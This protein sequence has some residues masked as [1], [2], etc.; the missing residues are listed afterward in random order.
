MTEKD[1][2]DLFQNI[3]EFQKDSPREEI[4]LNLSESLRPKLRPYQEEAVRWMIQRETI[5]T[6]PVGRSFSLHKNY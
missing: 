6:D 5:N 3:K 1:I 2:E 4:K